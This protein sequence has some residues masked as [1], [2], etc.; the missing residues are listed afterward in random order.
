MFISAGLLS[1]EEKSRPPRPSSP[2][3]LVAAFIWDTTKPIRP[4]QDNITREQ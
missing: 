2:I 1:T 4:Q 3:P